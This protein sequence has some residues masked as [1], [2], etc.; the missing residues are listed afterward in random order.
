MKDP[1][2]REVG[3]LV[4]AA[5]LRSILSE[6]YPKSGIEVFV[7][8]LDTGAS[9]WED[10]RVLA[11]AINV[12]SA[13]LV[14]AGVEMVDLV[15]GGVAGLDEEGNVV[16]DLVTGKACVAVGYMAGRDEVTCVWSRGSVGVEE[17]E[18]LMAKAVEMAREA[19]L[20]VNQAVAERL[21]LQL[22]KNKAST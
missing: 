21:L 12:G 8:V 7:E 11:G 5:L 19:R 9:K 6:R 18:K 20:V 2:E 15:T 13:A 17:F 22:E 14:E 10:A 1:G 16:G 3:S 4:Q